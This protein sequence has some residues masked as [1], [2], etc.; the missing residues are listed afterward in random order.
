MPLFIRTPQ[1][2]SAQAPYAAYL[3]VLSR[4]ATAVQ[5]A[6]RR[7]GL[8]NYEPEFQAALFALCEPHG[9]DLVFY[10]VGAHIGLYASLV[11]TL[12]NSQCIAFE[13]TPET[14]SICK[15]MKRANNLR[16]DIVEQ[17]VSNVDGEIDFFLSPTTESSNSLNG[18]FRAGARSIRI[19]VTSL[20]HF[21]RSGA[22]DPHV[23]KI[24]VETHEPQVVMGALKMIERARP[25]I[26]CELLTKID[27]AALREALQSLFALGY[28]A[29]HIVDRI[30]PQQRTLDELLA[31]VSS[32]DSDWIL[33]PR[34][35]DVGFDRAYRRWLLA[36]SDCRAQ[37]SVLS[38][39][40][41]ARPAV[42]TLQWPAHN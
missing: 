36:I 17:A 14:A 26:A 16:F 4:K 40:G 33:S 1:K 35:L 12:F 31:S 11:E 38:E 39:P 41:S 18:K 34:P 8:A 10:D 13:A 29:Y 20:D 7:G 28:T 32:T 42:T 25:A 2:Q 22:S 15:V 3:N 21:S 5:R 24:D 30:A 9:N 37:E 19:S 23:L 27:R 6:L